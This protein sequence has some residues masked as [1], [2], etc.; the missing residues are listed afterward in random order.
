[1]STSWFKL[2]NGIAV[3]MHQI[4]QV[5]FTELRQAIIAGPAHGRRV[6]AL[7]GRPVG[8]AGEAIELFAVLACDNGLVGF[9]TG[10]K[11]PRFSVRKPTRQSLNKQTS[12]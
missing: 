12:Y 3:P 5:P 11:T 2:R 4:Q 1:M 8:E 9:A 10:R 7:F 6:V